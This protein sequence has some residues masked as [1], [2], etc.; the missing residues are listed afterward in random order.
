[1]TKVVLPSEKVKPKWDESTDWGE[2]TW[3]VEEPRK[4]TER[5]LPAPRVERDAEEEKP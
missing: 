4:L 3:A 5:D 2:S 1:M